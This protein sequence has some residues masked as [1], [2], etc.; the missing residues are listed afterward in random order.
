MMS[1]VDYNQWAPILLAWRTD[2]SVRASIH[3]LRSNAGTPIRNPSN[4]ISYELESSWRIFFNI[5]KAI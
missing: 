4:L 2:L 5:L 1:F 3:F